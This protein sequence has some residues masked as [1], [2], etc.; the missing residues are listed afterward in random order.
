MRYESNYR[1][2]FFWESDGLPGISEMMDFFRSEMTAPKAKI[3][4]TKITKAILI[5]L[6]SLSAITVITAGISFA[7][8][9]SI[10][11]TVVLSMLV[12]FFLMGIMIIVLSILQF[13]VFPKACSEP[14]E[15][16]C[17]G[18]SISGGN[19]DGG[20]AGPTRCP[21]F[22]YSY[23]G[24][25]YTAFDHVYENRGNFPAVGSKLQILVNPDDPEELVWDLTGRRPR[26]L[27]LCGIFAI[28]LSAAIMF[29]V[30]N[31]KNF[32]D[33]AREDK[34]GLKDQVIEI[35]QDGN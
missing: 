7:I 30:L 2:Q 25:E 15:A 31:D 33:S 28:V 26:F 17:I 6:L 12:L 11:F 34:G 27:I 35:M 20:A 14:V 18:F 24:F 9:K 8:M 4:A 16:E 22:K 1:N 21:V 3:P 10:A 23:H 5:S 29:I 32:M 19:G 13:K